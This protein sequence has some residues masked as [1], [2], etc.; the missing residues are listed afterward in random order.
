MPR[1][2]F[3]IRPVLAD[4][5]TDA[6]R[7]QAIVTVE[8]RGV[9]RND[10][11][12]PASAKMPSAR[13]RRTSLRASSAVR[14]EADDY[15][16][17]RWIVTLFRSI[18]L[19]S[20]SKM[21]IPS[22]PAVIAFLARRVRSGRSGDPKPGRTRMPWLRADAI[23]FRSITLVVGIAKEQD[24]CTNTS[25]RD[26]RHGIAIRIAE[27]AYAGADVLNRAACDRHPWWPL[28]STPL[29]KLLPMPSIV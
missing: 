23:E 19:A 22:P 15:S 4:N 8:G 16:R 26:T 12:V 9:L 21:S 27:K 10:A 28:T 14:P 1:S 17:A 29:P 7:C 13:L 5:R 11:A 6:F 3:A 20:E 2:P 18:T 24:S 25:D